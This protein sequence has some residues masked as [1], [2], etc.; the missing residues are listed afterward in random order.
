MLDQTRVLNDLNYEINLVS[1]NNKID[2]NCKIILP[3]VGNFDSFIKSLKSK[4]LLMKK[5]ISFR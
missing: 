3:G 4:N 2:K 5:K 1:D